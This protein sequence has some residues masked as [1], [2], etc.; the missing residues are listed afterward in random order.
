MRE[1]TRECY[2][3]YG[4]YGSALGGTRDAHTLR[5]IEAASRIALAAPP[6]PPRPNALLPKAPLS[7]ALPPPALLPPAAPPPQPLASLGEA[8]AEREEE[9]EEKGLLPKWLRH[10]GGGREPEEAAPSPA[11]ATTSPKAE[12]K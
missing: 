12:G 8:A 11:G 6:A 1:R 7:L 10:E 5:G 4:G 2:G 3:S 9:T